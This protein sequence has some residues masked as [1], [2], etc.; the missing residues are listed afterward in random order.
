M[1][2]YPPAPGH[3]FEEFFLW[4]ERKDPFGADLSKYDCIL[5]LDVIEHLTEP[6]AFLESLRAHSASARHS[7]RIIVTTGNVVFWILRL[8]A[9]L[10]NFNYGKRGILD[11]THS[12]LYTFR[13]L[14]QLFRQCG[15]AVER[16]E[17]VPAPFPKALGLNAF[18][19]ALVKANDW[20]NALLPGLFA[21]QI[22]LEARPLTTVDALLDD[23]IR[24]AQEKAE[25]VA[26]VAG[27]ARA[28]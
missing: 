4:D 28:S 7:P 20:M 1:D 10:G 13:T 25:P 14:K 6:E 2:R 12:R 11:L 24:T 22:F 16:T 3:G 5:L 21:Y 19:R 18:A 17:A 23:A 15:F 8:Q 27:S 26:E 9:L